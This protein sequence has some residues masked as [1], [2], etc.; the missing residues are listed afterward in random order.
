M[1]SFYFV[2][3]PLLAFVVVSMENEVNASCIWF[4]YRPEDKNKVGDIAQVAKGL[5]RTKQGAGSP[6]LC[7]SVW[8]MSAI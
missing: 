2:L 4:G 5:I 3:L 1:G 8:Y 7:K 6:S